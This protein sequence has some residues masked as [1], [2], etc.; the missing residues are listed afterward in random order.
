MYNDNLSSALFSTKATI[1]VLKV[2]LVF[3]LLGAVALAWAPSENALEAAI[4][5]GYC[6]VFTSFGILVPKHIRLSVRLIIYQMPIFF[7]ALVYFN[8]L[9]PTPF[10]GLLTIMPLVLLGGREGI[11]IA[12]LISMTPL[13]LIPLRPDELSPVFYRIL[14]TNFA[15]TLLF[16]YLVDLVKRT[17]E[18]ASNS[19]KEAEKSAIHA[20][21][22]AQLSEHASRAKSDFLAN[23]SHEIRTPLNG[24]FGSL[25]VIRSHLD[26]K[27]TIAL[28]TNV[29]MQSYHS[30]IGIVND[31][32]DLSKLAEDKVDIYP[33]PSNVG[34]IVELV[35]AELK[36]VTLN[37]GL[38]LVSNCTAEVD[39]QNRLIDRTRLAQLLRNLLSNAIKFTDSG[40]VKIEARLGAHSDEV[41]F[42]ITDTGVGIPGDK[43]EK[44]FEPFEQSDASRKTERTG[45]GLGLAISKRL[46]ELMDGSISVES[47]VGVGTR[48]TLRV[49]LPETEIPRTDKRGAIDI[50]KLQPARILLAEDVATNRMIF[51]ALL[52]DCPYTIDEAENGEAAVEKALAQ[53]YDLVFMDIQ[54]PVMDGL[55]A[56]SALK[57][58]KYPKPIIACTAN[59]MKEDVEEYMAAGFASV[60]GK[61]YLKEDLVAIIQA[62]VTRENLASSDR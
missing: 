7:G 24:I 58:V 48:F 5:V 22:S 37:K 55:S 18:R 61:P 2:L 45:T 3:L 19:Q 17:L 6:I 20:A 44:I 49:N 42:T 23:M 31:I 40:R 33:E 30:V 52:K 16:I 11:A 57:T 29:A 36:A 43:L 12:L 34:E 8:G 4:I 28:Y 26:D 35:T 21:E 51:G 39:A 54:M 41:M 14:F 15:A 9:V 13:M 62:A 46:V 56:L 32:L 25:Q 60:I 50:T 10:A 59:V 47:E 1:A 53:E 38:D 27:S